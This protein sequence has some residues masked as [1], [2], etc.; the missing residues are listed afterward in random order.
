MPYGEIWPIFEYNQNRHVLFLKHTVYFC[1]TLYLYLITIT[2]YVNSGFNIIVFI[3]FMQKVC[4]YNIPSYHA[5]NV[6]NFCLT[7]MEYIHTT[8]VF[9]QI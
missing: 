8:R 2:L 3:M 4:M 9:L 1:Y 5:I 6:F 7:G